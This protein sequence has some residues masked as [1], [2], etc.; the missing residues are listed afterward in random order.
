[1]RHVLAESPECPLGY[2]LKNKKKHPR[3]RLEYHCK[4][5]PLPVHG[6]SIRR[7]GCVRGSSHACVDAVASSFSL[8]APFVGAKNDRGRPSL[9]LC[10]LSVSR[11]MTFFIRCASFYRKIVHNQ[12]ST[13]VQRKN[14]KSGFLCCL[15]IELDLRKI[16]EILGDTQLQR[17]GSDGITLSVLLFWNYLCAT[18]N[19]VFRGV[20][21]QNGYKST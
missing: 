6:N 2:V 18:A 20:E 13:L 7:G 10:M 16:A 17:C 4:I 5:T 14:N 8:F 1:M 15:A 19:T 12:S 21:T 11:L 9:D 3:Y